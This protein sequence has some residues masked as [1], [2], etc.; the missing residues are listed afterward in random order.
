MIARYKLAGKVILGTIIS[1]WIMTSRVWGNFST[2][3]TIP[4]LKNVEID[5]GRLYP[6]MVILV[7]AGTPTQ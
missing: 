3:T 2:K 4:F 5:L 7:I 1:V 6:L